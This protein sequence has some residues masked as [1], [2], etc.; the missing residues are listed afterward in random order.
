MKVAVLIASILAL[1]GTVSAQSPTMIPPSPT[2]LQTPALVLPQSITLAP[3]NPSISSGQSVQ[4]TATL[5]FSNGS[6]VSTPMIWNTSNQ[7][8]AVVQA[9]G[10]VTGRRAG[11]A[12]ITASFSDITATTTVTVR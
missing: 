5:V 4:L 1:A 9:S 2:S 3:Q 10:M 7:R 6:T 12:Q 11:S 8:V